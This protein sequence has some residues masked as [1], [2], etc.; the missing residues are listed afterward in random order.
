MYNVSMWVIEIP[1]RGL[2]AWVIFHVRHMIYVLPFRPRSWWHTVIWESGRCFLYNSSLNQLLWTSDLCFLE[3]LKMMLH[4][5]KLYVPVFV[6]FLKLLHMPY[7]F[8]I[9][10]FD[11]SIQVI[12]F[13]A[14]ICAIFLESR[15]NYS[16]NL[17][18][19]VSA[20]KKGW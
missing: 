11:V 2:S 8:E 7:L 15:F 19:G 18:R 6:T 9:P 4:F 17:C 12:N 1:E 5:F 14:E 3:Y 10:A 20:I 16:Y 13:E